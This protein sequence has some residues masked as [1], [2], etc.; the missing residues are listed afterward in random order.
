MAIYIT[1]SEK[2]M[3]NGIKVLF[4]K[5]NPRRSMMG[6]TKS[7]YFQSE[8]LPFPDIKSDITNKIANEIMPINVARYGILNPIFEKNRSSRIALLKIIPISMN[9]GG[10][11]I[12]R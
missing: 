9:A 11:K 10:D 4:L 2:A 3:L 1:T 8:I 6:M 12:N 5:R 7:A